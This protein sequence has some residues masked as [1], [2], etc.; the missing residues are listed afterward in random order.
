MSSP[1]NISIVIPV[2]HEEEVINEAVD[3]L[4][5]LTFESRLEIIVV[6]GDPREQTLVAIGDSRVIKARSEKGRGKQMNA[7]A[8]LAS[9]EVLLF[10][11]VDTELPPD[12]LAQIDRVMRDKDC[13]GGSFDLGIGSDKLCFRLIERAASLRSRI[14]RMPYGD[15]GI[16]LRR[17]FF[18]DL[19]GF[20]EL[21]LMEDVDLMRRVRQSGKKIHIIA[22]KVKTSARRWEKE[23]VVY[24]TLRN[25][26]LILLYL[27]GVSPQRLAQLYP[28][29]EQ[30]QVKVKEK[31]G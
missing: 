16:F 27:L 9:G 13:V 29:H 20:R 12:G 11:H 24:C 21:P 4:H 10:L 5:R 30:T 3:A 19:G 26:M 25:W 6:D 8:M 23:G 22:R 31:A 14:T 1:C 18:F 7:G 28:D 15:Q 17:E 2:F